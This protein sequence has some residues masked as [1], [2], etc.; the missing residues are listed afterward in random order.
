M[1]QLQ[2]PLTCY[3]CINLGNLGKN[4]ITLE[5]FFLIVAR[6]IISTRYYKQFL[7]KKKEFGWNSS[8][9]INIFN[10]ILCLILSHPWAGEDLSLKI[11]ERDLTIWICALEF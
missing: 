2:K 9:A 8:F 10:E 7:P 1:P 5:I 4:Q 3:P 6:I 11:D